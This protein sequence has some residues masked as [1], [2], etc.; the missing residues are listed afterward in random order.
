MPGELFT[1]KKLL[2]R[3]EICGIMP[4]VIVEDCASA[5]SVSRV[6]NGIAL[7]G[8]SYNLYSLINKLQGIEDIRI[9]LDNDAMLKSIKLQY[10]LL[11]AGKFRKVEI[12]RANDD[13]KYLKCEELNTLIYGKQ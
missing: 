13:L 12:L 9:C 7:C 3:D 10:D 4:Y 11:G 1:A 8:T 5:C 2:T 6:A